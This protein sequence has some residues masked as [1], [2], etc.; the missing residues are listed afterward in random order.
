MGWGSNFL[1]FCLYETQELLNS[2]L[3]FSEFSLKLINWS[4]HWPKNILSYEADTVYS[5]YLS[6]DWFRFIVKNLTKLFSLKVL[7]FFFKMSLSQLL[8]NFLNFQ[9]F[10]PQLLI[11]SILIRKNECT[12]YVVTSWQ[13]LFYDQ[14]HPLNVA[15]WTSN[16]PRT[17]Q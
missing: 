4:D 9:E 17:M 12:R 2:F 8:N 5:L 1:N 11:N 15:L 6:V 14:N 3:N 10:E 7:N 16:P 13:I